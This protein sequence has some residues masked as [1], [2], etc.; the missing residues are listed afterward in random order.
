M[1]TTR[2]TGLKYDKIVIC[3]AA[4]TGTTLLHLMMRTFNETLVFP[5]E[6]PGICVP[7]LIRFSPAVMVTKSPH[8]VELLPYIFIMYPHT[9]AIVTIRD[10]RDTLC[11]RVGADYGY[12]LYKPYYAH[13]IASAMRGEAWAVH[14]NP[15]KVMTVKYEDL[16]SSPDAVQEQIIKTTGLTPRLPFSRYHEIPDIPRLND[17][18]TARPVFASSVG[19]WRRPE[20][21]EWMREVLMAEIETHNRGMLAHLCMLSGYEQDDSWMA[22]ILP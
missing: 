22:V 18:F 10:P 11:S 14:S 1:E 17:E 6:V 8:D 9:L 19:T 20:N 21:R 16:V 12:R 15:D 3:G 2:P 7:S 13:R 4:R 5:G